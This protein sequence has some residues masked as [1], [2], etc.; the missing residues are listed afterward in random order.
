M[1]QIIINDLVNENSYDLNIM[2]PQKLYF[3]IVDVC[4]YFIDKIMM[5][6]FVDFLTWVK[7]T[8][9]TSLQR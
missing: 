7:I 4:I 8:S 9:F 6:N 2:N 3:N 1:S 5:K